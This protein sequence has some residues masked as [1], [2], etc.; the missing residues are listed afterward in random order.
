MTGKKRIFGI[1]ASVL[2]C[3][4]CTVHLISNFAY[5]WQ[6]ISLGAVE[7]L[8]EEQSPY[9]LYTAFRM[10]SALSVC[11]VML[12]GVVLSVVSIVMA[13][14]GSEKVRFFLCGVLGTLVL[15]ALIDIILSYASYVIFF[16]VVFN[17]NMLIGQWPHVFTMLAYILMIVLLI[18]SR[19]NKKSKAFMLWLV[20]PIVLA[21]TQVISRIVTVVNQM[22]IWHD[23][24][25]N[26][27]LLVAPG[28]IGVLN[29]I[30][31][32]VGVVFIG[33]AYLTAFT[34]KKNL[35]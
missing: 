25:R 1:L 14:K 22:I 31:C 26:L 19:K 32:V 35:V 12:G 3:I 28:V 27:I 10:V 4:C 34:K 17:V 24:I 20:A 9:S 11:F 21:W 5:V 15:K 13:K 30:I 23:D 2:L 8:F 7:H 6:I 29:G 33:F 18:N 16:N